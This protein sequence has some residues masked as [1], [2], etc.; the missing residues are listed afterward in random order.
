MGFSYSY[1]HA[2]CYTFKI[3]FYQ[4]SVHKSAYTSG[5]TNIVKGKRRVLQH[6]HWELFLDGEM[7]LNVKH[8]HLKVISQKL[9]LPNE[10]S[11]KES[12]QWPCWSVKGELEV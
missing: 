11:S 10:L 7:D 3:Y 4:I 9:Y 2:V 8:S 6:F 12:K 1:C 5:H